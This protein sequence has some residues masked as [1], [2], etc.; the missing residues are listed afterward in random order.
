MTYNCMK[1]PQNKKQIDLNLIVPADEY[2]AICYLVV[3]VQIV[4]CCVRE[5]ERG[6]LD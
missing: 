4:C 6:L 3:A 1:Q 5:R 2:E